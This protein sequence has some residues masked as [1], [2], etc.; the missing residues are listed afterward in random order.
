MSTGLT[1]PEHLAWWRAQEHPL[2]PER[3][4][5]HSKLVYY[6]MQRKILSEFKCKAHQIL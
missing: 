3:E 6:V 5:Q 2:K 1:P 4:F